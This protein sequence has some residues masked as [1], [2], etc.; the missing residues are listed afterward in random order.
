MNRREFFKV[1]GGG[2][3]VGLL[4]GTGILS[5]KAW[6]KVSVVRHSRPMLGTLIT[7]TVHHSDLA[8]AE[9][10]MTKAFQAIEEVDRVMS[11]HRSDS[12]I[13]RVNR[14]AGVEEILVHPWLVEVLNQASKA[15]ALTQGSYDV[16][17]LPLMRLYGFY[18]Q[19][20]QKHF[21]KDKEILRVLDSV[22]QKFII[23][24]DRSNR[25]GLMKSESGIDLG[26]IGKGFAVDRAADVL[27]KEGIENALIDAG[28]NIFA[29]GTPQDHSATEEGWK[30]AIRNPLGSGEDDYFEI[31]TLR[32]A[33]VA[34]SGNYE[35]SVL[36]DGR[37]V[38]HLF[39]LR[40]GKPSETGT[41]AT[42][43]T[44]SATWA[45]AL[46]TSAYLLGPEFKKS[47]VGQSTE[48]Y[49]HGFAG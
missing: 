13:V 43:V 17:C 45:D 5:Y 37:R 15:H 19:E 8:V 24:D 10:G 41:S 49:F 33:A 31:L 4:T 6:N 32:N 29:L 42:V 12:D 21:P 11:L 14:A 39:N 26:S 20:N 35:Q 1:L 38:G 46:S 23:I 28:G 40:H 36:L 9:R 2:V 25:M 16:T 7:M 47:L 30:V 27:R 44:S 22:G 18:S 34:T 48:I 3:G